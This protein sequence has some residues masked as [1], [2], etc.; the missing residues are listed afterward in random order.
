VPSLIK[1]AQKALMEDIEMVKTVSN[2]SVCLCLLNKNQ[3]TNI[4]EVTRNF[5]KEIPDVREDIYYVL[6]KIRDRL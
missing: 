5:I 3:K 4:K 6:A 2:I 1:V